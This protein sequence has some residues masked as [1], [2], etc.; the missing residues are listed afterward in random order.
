MAGLS[1][2]G[3]KLQ[4]HKIKKAENYYSYDFCNKNY[5]KKHFRKRDL[6][7]TKPFETS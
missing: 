7:G 2:K 3:L 1:I 6:I 5:L 4:F